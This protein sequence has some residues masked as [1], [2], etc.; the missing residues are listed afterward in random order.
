M[1]TSCTFGK[2]SSAIYLGNL[3]FCNFVFII[4][5]KF[6]VHILIGNLARQFGGGVYLKVV[7]FQV[8]TLSLSLRQQ[9]C[10]HAFLFLLVYSL[11]KAFQVS[12][13]SLS[14]R[15]QVKS[16]NRNPWLLCKKSRQRTHFE[17]GLLYER[18]PSPALIGTSPSSNTTSTTIQTW[19][20]QQ[21][22]L[23]LK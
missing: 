8:S 10:M 22:Q 5:T 16:P 18:S 2:L 4:F 3:H 17:R 9:V 1:I 19:Q 6:W 13:L 23:R 20:R 11:I 21:Q 15:Q 14:L 12:T 7:T